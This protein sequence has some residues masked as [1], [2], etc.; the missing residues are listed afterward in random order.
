MNTSYL[1][2]IIKVAL[3]SFLVIV[4]NFKEFC[5]GSC[6]TRNYLRHIVFGLSYTHLPC[7]GTEGDQKEIVN[8][9]MNYKYIL[10][11]T[12]KLT[13]CDEEATNKLINRLG[14]ILKVVN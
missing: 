1:H 3:N 14:Y 12:R 10:N 11:M 5:Q 4:S 6:F 8:R 2:R 7:K 9:E 13:K